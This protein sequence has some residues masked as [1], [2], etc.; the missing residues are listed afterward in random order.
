MAHTLSEVF[1]VLPGLF[2]HMGAFALLTQGNIEP[3][4]YL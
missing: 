2:G 3:A 1:Y 4:K